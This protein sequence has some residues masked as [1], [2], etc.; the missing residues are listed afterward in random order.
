MSCKPDVFQST[1]DLLTSGNKNQT[2]VWESPLVPPSTYIKTKKGGPI[3]KKIINV[4]LVVR[5]D[6]MINQSIV[7]SQLTSNF[8]LT[9]FFMKRDA[10][11]YKTL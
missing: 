3:H 11:P 9:Y 1:I 5:Y 7:T 4:K 10:L 2:L 6:T 8:T